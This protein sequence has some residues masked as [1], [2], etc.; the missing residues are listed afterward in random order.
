MSK[1]RDQFVLWIVPGILWTWLFFHLHVEWT[2]NPQYTYGWG[3][4]F[5][6]LLLFYFRWQTRPA[7]DATP[8][9]RGFAVGTA[10]FCLALLFPLRIIEEAN[11]DWRLLSWVLAFDVIAISLLSL[12]AVGGLSWLKHFAFP[13]CLPL[14][15][16]P[17]PVRFE[18]VVVQ[19]MMRGVAYAAVEI[20]GWLG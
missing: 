17:W 16:V 8:R 20:A 10:L 6:A 3:A 7:P 15:A 14:A 5:L 2:L 18:S 13:V 19:N 9:K 11:P 1:F 4:P 12:V